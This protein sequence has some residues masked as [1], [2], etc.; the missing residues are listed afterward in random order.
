MDLD[1]DIYRSVV[2]ITGKDPA[3]FGTGFAFFRDNK[4]TYFLTCTHVIKEVGGADGLKV[5]GNQAQVIA[6]DQEDGF[7][8]AVVCVYKILE[9]PVLNLCFFPGRDQ[10][11]VTT[12]FSE[13]SKKR[14]LGKLDGVLREQVG[15]FSQGPETTRGIAWRIAITDSEQLQKGYSGAPVISKATGSVLAVMSLRQGTGEKGLAVS[16]AVLSQFWKEMPPDLIAAME[17]SAIV[18]ALPMNEPWMNLRNE[19]AAFNKIALGQDAE[20]VLIL[21][22]GKTGMGKTFLMGKY[23]EVAEANGIRIREFNLKQQ[24]TIEECI[25]R[26]VENFGIQNF[27]E[28]DSLTTNRL[29]NTTRP[30]ESDWQGVLTRKFF[31]DLSKCKELQPLIVMFDQYEAADRAFKDWLT[32]TFITKL[33]PSYPLI[34]VVAGQE[35]ISPSVPAKCVRHFPLKGVTVDLYQWYAKELKALL[36]VEEIIHYHE[37]L[38]GEPKRFVEMVAAR[39]RRGMQNG[40]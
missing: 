23:K 26:L 2:L 15:L 1:Q 38:Q 21:I 40:R 27:P 18:A 13:Q 37:A 34:V 10:S 35:E 4:S 33:S 30:Q 11:I 25:E 19:L 36:T 14:L 39:Q 28:Y 24:L 3:R 5:D 32:R 9:Q 17:K 29:N 7:D 20:T 12:G 31:L 22:S 8:L 16:V 6:S